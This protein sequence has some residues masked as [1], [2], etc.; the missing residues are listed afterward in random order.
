MVSKYE[1]PKGLTL[2]LPVS[3]NVNMVR[4]LPTHLSFAPEGGSSGAQA[5]YWP[6]EFVDVLLLNLQQG[7]LASERLRSEFP[8]YR[9]FGPGPFSLPLES[10]E[11][12][13]R[14]LHSLSR[15]GTLIV[16]PLGH[17]LKGCVQTARWA[18]VPGDSW[19]I[20][21]T[22]TTCGQSLPEI[23]PY[24]LLFLIYPLAGA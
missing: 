23:W 11:E 2:A 4:V 14:V 18:S 21:S 9:L 15:S 3:F 7:L 19:V 13:A 24:K 5:S 16:F 1:L 6:V 10:G 12:E 8:I 20:P 17:V 22:Q